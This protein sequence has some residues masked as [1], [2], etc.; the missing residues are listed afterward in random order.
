M[1][2]EYKDNPEHGLRFILTFQPSTSFLVPMDRC[3][4]LAKAGLYNS[5]SLANDKHETYYQEQA[6]KFLHA[7]LATVLNLRTPEHTANQVSHTKVVMVLSLLEL[8]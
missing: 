3:V 7:C 8:R 6:L 1:L 4:A 5:S 2:L